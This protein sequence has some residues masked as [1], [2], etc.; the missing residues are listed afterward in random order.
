MEGSG[1]ALISL[2]V[3][4][5]RRIHDF[6]QQIIEEIGKANNIQDR[7]NRQ[8][9]Q[10]ALSSV[11]EI[12]K[13]Y[14]NTPPNGLAIY[15]GSI[16]TGNNDT[17][18]VM[19]K[20]EPYLPIQSK[21]FLCSTK[22]ELEP[23]KQL[24]KSPLKYGFIVMDGHGVLFGLLQGENKF[25]LKTI[26]VNLPNKHGKGGQSQNRYANIRRG[27]R[28]RYVKT[29]AEEAVGKFISNNVINVQ[30]LIL[31]GSADFKKQLF[32]GQFFDQRLKSK[33]IKLIDVSYGQE[34]GFNQAIE[35]SKDAIKNVKL[36][37]QQELLKKFF[38]HISQETGKI[39]YGFE[40]TLKQ[41]R[42][43]AV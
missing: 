16:K 38:G 13:S 9:V 2:I 25:V 40:S 19:F 39:V 26:S 17:K 3:P 24:L 36:I 33:V 8:A 21:K 30:G 42:A 12:L 37:Q 34:E 1:T 14:K 35:L 28:L 29:V 4:K 22:F 18:K 43:G 32:N 6:T 10:T 20:V 5:G 15:C 27:K 31:A 11:K 41:I 23:L 7:V